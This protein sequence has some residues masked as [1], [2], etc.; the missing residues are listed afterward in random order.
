MLKK[1]ILISTVLV[2]L[3]CTQAVAHFMWI[4]ANDF[5]PGKGKNLFFS[6]G[7]GHYFYN[8]V[9]SILLKGDKLEDIH[10]VTSKGKNVGIKSINDFQYKTEKKIGEGTHLVVLKRQ[11]G[12]VTKTKNGKKYYSSKKGHKDVT[13][14]RF[15][16]MY[17]KAVINSG[18]A[19]NSRVL[20]KPQGL[21]L[22]LVP[23]NNPANLKE[24]DYLE[25]RLLNKGKPLAEYFN[26]TY[27]GFSQDEA[28]S[29]S[30]RTGKDGKARLRISNPGIWVIKVN[31]KEKYPDPK[32]S[33]LTSLTT[34]LTFEVK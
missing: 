31:H 6:I 23:L 1:K 18:K 5:T 14:S 3:I 4:N 24:G 25:F 19:A 21:R 30:G 17:G 26:A 10:L 27:L 34:S 9:K 29:Y 15:I 2:M 12:F 13:E 33:D 8:P 11:E 7:W 32:L 28:W 16:G 20:S 22:E